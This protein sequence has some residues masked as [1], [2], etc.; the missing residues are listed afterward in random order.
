[1]YDEVKDQNFIIIAVAQESRGEETAREW[2]DEAKPG[3]V[4]LI[5]R[6]HHVADLY[7][8]VN[9]PQSVWID[10]QG[11]IVRPTETAG[12]HDG[13]RSM[14]RE[15]LSMPDASAAIV[16]KA[17]ET[18]VGAVRDW[19][20]N[21]AASRHAF[22]PEEARA[23]LELPDDKVALANANFRLGRYLHAIGKTD[24]A[25]A[26]LQAASDLR[27]GSWNIYRQAMN[28][29]EIGPLG[30]A[31]DAGFFEKVDALGSDRYYPPPDIEGF[32]NE[33]GFRPPD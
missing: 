32:P 7:N 18:Y 8:M 23:H 27:P 33:L 17:Q 30:L 22:S 5:D 2:I 26:F 29:K 6:D 16:A 24:E 25:D 9:V 19:A 28:L 4:T 1:M 3:Y 21:G 31:A 14:N 10:E 13:W 11:R 15:D 12:S 20:V